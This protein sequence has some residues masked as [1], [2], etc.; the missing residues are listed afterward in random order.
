MA[1]RLREDARKWFESFVPKKNA[2][3]RTQFDYYYLCAMI[4]FLTNERSEPNQ[5]GHTAKEIVNDFTSDY[6]STKYS[7]VG[8]L[9]GKQLNYRHKGLFDRSVVHQE[10]ERLMNSAGSPALSADGQRI[11][12]RWAS[13]GFDVIFR[14]INPRPQN[15]RQFFLAYLNLV[16]TKRSG[17]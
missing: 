7:I 11:L 12:D 5:N 10:I 15:E 1:F 3:L 16:A 6:D 9:V 17:G 14:E 8:L 2:T 13:G 4:G